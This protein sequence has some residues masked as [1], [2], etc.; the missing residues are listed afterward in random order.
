D[1]EHEDPRA[2]VAALQPEGADVVL[3]CAGRPASAATCLD[4]VRRK[5]RYAQV[6]LYGKPV[7]LDFDQV[8]Y[9]ELVV[10]GSNAS[11]PWVWEKAIALIAGGRVK[12]APLVA[13]PVALQDWPAAF[14]RFEAKTGLKQLFA[15]GSP[16]GKPN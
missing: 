9:K 2:V 4:L 13:A 11:V 5:G 1:V 15:P 14:A 10:T 12:T 7:T 6:G 8:C 3:E 16:L